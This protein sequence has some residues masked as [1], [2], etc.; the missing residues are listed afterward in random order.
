[1][2]IDVVSIFPEY[3]AALELSLI[4]KARQD[5]VLDV[6]IHDLR[7]FTTDRH[8]TVDDTPYGGGAGMVMKPEPWAQ[9]LEAVR[10]DAPAT[11]PTLIVPSP[12][13][14]V[15][16]QAMAHELAG[17]DHLVF[18]C[19]RYEGI[20]ERAVDWARDEFDV[21]PVSLGDYVLN[22][23]EVAVLAMVEAVGR[24]IPGVV[25]NPESLVEESHAD[26]L[27]EYPVYTKP[28]SWRGRDVPEV[29]LSGNHAKIAQWRR[30]EQFKRTADRRPDLLGRVDAGALRKAD[31]AALRAAGFDVVDGRL[32]RTQH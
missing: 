32:T 17:H 27:L 7:S 18:A 25:G 15:F 14:A 19:G 20:D 31:L 13:G 23:G 5:G 30:L 22:G 2:R 28:S 16:D 8:R 21:R 11:R 10:A 9:A 3:L 26:G 24:L 1:M 12:A 4:G 29:L 6:R